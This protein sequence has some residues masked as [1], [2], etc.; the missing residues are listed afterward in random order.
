M[1]QKYDYVAVKSELGVIRDICREIWGGS[2]VTL[3]ASSLTVVLDKAV[4]LDIDITDILAII[5]DIK[6][7]IQNISI[8]VKSL[9][10]ENLNLVRDSLHKTLSKL[11]CIVES[12]IRERKSAIIDNVFSIEER[13]NVIFDKTLQDYDY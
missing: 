4:M 7:S 3:Q 9:P 11:A 1:E 2:N 13:V 8:I 6:H 12:R 5:P 10:E